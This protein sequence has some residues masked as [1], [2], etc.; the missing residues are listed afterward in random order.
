MFEMQLL[1]I[2]KQ[3][4]KTPGSE[5]LPYIPAAWLLAGPATQK[6]CLGMDFSALMQSSSQ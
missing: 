1:N 3:M 2:L 5:E 4:H 6:E